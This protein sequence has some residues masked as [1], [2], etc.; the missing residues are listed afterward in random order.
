MVRRR[1]AARKIPSPEALREKKKFSV[2][3]NS[4][5]LPEEGRMWMEKGA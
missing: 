2:K 4:R 5:L 3:E 1:P